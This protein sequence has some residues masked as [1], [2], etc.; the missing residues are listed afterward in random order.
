MTKRVLFLAALCSVSILSNPV[1]AKDSI[2]AGKTIEYSVAG[3]TIQA[4]FL[5]D[6]QLRWTYLKAPT[7]AEVGKTAIETTDNISLR[8]DVVLVAWTETSGANVVDVF[9][10]GKRKVIANFVMPD[11]KRYQSVADFKIVKKK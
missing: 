4:E 7:P 11:G 8:R 9:D 2:A 5:S 6:R 10:F 3:Y 1:W